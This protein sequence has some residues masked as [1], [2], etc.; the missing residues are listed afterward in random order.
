M[1]DPC[2]P[3]AAVRWMRAARHSADH[4]PG[5]AGRRAVPASWVADC[6]AHR[7]ASFC[8]PLNGCTVAVPVWS[9]PNAEQEKD[10]KI[11][12]YPAEQASC[13][14]ALPPRSAWP[15]SSVSPD[16]VDQQSP[17]PG[18]DLPGLS[19]LNFELSCSGSRRGPKS[20]Q[21]PLS[22]PESSY[23]YQ[24]GLKWMKHCLNLD[25]HPVS[26]KPGC[27]GSS[28]PHAEFSCVQSG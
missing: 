20:E 8:S 1:G 3:A 25:A 17:P 9:G 19:R 6:M 5:A 12:C 4:N 27:A 16:S 11:S 13:L 10:C 28:S 22:Q 18:L 15:C 24:W 26:V 14:T 7:R 23:K 2:K 21:Q